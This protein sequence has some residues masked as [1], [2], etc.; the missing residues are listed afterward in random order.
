ME[1]L[2]VARGLADRET[3]IAMKTV[4]VLYLRLSQRFEEKDLLPKGMDLLRQAEEGLRAVFGPDHPE[5]LNATTNRAVGYLQQERTDQAKHLLEDAIGRM[6][7]GSGPEHPLVLEAKTDLGTVFYALGMFGEAARI[8]DGVLA[9]QN[10]VLKPSHPST[11]KTMAWLGNSYLMMV[12]NAGAEPSRQQ[13]LEAKAEPL[14]QEALKECRKALDR[15]HSTTVLVLANLAGLYSLKALAKKNGEYL[16]QV[17]EYLIEAAEIS[18]VHH[19]AD[20]G[21]TDEANVA[22][23]HFYLSMHYFAGGD[24][25]AAVPYAR[26][27]RDY[28]VRHKPDHID[29]YLAEV[30]L[31]NC[32]L[33][34]RD[35]PEAECS[36]IRADAMKSVD[37]IIELYQKAGD[38][39]KVN[40]WKLKRLDLNFPDQPLAP[41]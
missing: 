36:R 6:E 17:G 33:L 30:H 23:S 41:K 25:S 34:R 2:R 29:R 19:G 28:C 39:Q 20:D 27:H 12:A 10:R 22:V 11:L 15:N 35:L 40:E 7:Q 26:A 1:G 5:T 21:I 14:L 37:R 38:A 8:L 31:G 16:K 3:L 32:L 9:V 24:V 13:A 18:R 4:G